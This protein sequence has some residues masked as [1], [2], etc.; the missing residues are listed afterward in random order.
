MTADTKNN[1]FFY[2]TN[3]VGTCSLLAGTKNMFPAV[4]LVVFT[5]FFEAEVLELKVFHKPFLK[6]S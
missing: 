6:L 4:F 2:H 1:L 3:G 5:F